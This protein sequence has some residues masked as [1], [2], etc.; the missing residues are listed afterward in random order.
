MV[1]REASIAEWST[2]LDNEPF[3]N[4]LETEGE[5]WFTL[6]VHQYGPVPREMG[7]D[8]GEWLY[9][10]RATLDNCVY[11]VAAHDTG[12]NPPRNFDKLAFPLCNTEHSWRSNQYKIEGLSEK[13]RGWIHDVQPYRSDKGPDT[14]LWYWVNELAR[15]DRHRSLH[16]VGGLLAVVEPVVD[17]PS[18]TGVF[19]EDFE[20]ERFIEHEAVLARFKV[21]PWTEGDKVEANPRTGIDPEIREWAERNPHP[22]VYRRFTFGARLRH[23]ETIIRCFVGLM[24]R[25]CTGRTRSDVEKLLRSPE[26][27]EAGIAPEE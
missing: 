19:F 23:M 22:E 24:E 17:A 16:V 8:L 3:Y 4:T 15:I 1:H 20:L 13:H 26:E 7:L 14:S 11:L 2:F 6:W 9:H 10:L 5:G 25:D 12:E 21:E 18:A 27:I